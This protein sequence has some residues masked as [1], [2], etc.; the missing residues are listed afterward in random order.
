MTLF[1]HPPRGFRLSPFDLA[2]LAFGVLAAVLTRGLPGDPSTLIAIVVGHFF[3][4]RNV[5]RLRRA[6]ELA[7]AGVFVVLAVIG[8]SLG[9]QSWVPPLVFITPYT[10]LLVV[11]EIQSGRYHGAFADGRPVRW[12]AGRNPGRKPRREATWL[13]VGAVLVL[14]VGFVGSAVLALPMAIIRQRAVDQSRRIQAAAV[15]WRTGHPGRCPSFEDLIHTG[16]LHSRF[17][18][19]DP[20]NRPYAITCTG[21]EVTVTSAG[22]DGVMGTG[23]DV[24]VPRR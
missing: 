17:S 16:K 12:L 4:F 13:S 3:F 24:G 19:Q 14:G 1:R 15:Q 23:D 5:V 10:V 8:W 22:P 21:P 7:W 6:F 2:F 11:L 18:V 9:I 20:W